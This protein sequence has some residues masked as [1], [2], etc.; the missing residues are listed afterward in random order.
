MQLTIAVDYATRALMHLASQPSPKAVLI[1]QIAQAEN[2]PKSFLAKILQ[3][4]VKAGFVRSRRGTKGGFFLACN[5]DELTMRQVV[6]AIDGPV[7]FRQCILRWEGCPH[8]RD[9]ALCDV[10]L[11]AEEKMLELLEKSRIAD[12]LLYEK[13]KGAEIRQDQP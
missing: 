1:S 8:E 3:D 9:C 5:A 4:L 6:E 13:Q 10:W 11:E 2:I 12:L 7:V